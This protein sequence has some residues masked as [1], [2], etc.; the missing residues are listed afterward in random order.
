M[1]R[2]QVAG[3]DEAHIHFWLVGHRQ[4]GTAFDRKR[5]MRAAAVERKRIDNSGILHPGQSFYA[6]QY[7]TEEIYFAAWSRKTAA[8]DGDV[9]REHVAGVEAGAD[10]AKL[11]ER[12]DHQSR[13]DEQNERKRDFGDDEDVT[14]FAASIG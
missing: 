2:A 5:L 6:L 13:A 11:P 10:I 3:A 12:A 1:H 8:R 9:H 7:I 4:H 14:C